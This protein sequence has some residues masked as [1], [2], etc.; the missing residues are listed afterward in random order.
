MHPTCDD[1]VNKTSHQEPDSESGHIQINHIYC[2]RQKVL[3]VH[4]KGH[5]EPFKKQQI[6]ASIGKQWVQSITSKQRFN[7]SN[8]TSNRAN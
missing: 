2:L 1:Y 7:M 3:K 8:Q 4:V 6:A 5:R